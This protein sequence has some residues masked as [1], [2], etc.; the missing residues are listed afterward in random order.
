MMTRSTYDS[1]SLRCSFALGFITI[2]GLVLVAA[3]AQGQTRLQPAASAQTTATPPSLST[4]QQSFEVASIR[5]CAKDN[6]DPFSQNPFPSNRLALHNVS[7]QWA[8]AMAYKFDSRHISGPSW[9][10][11]LRY[12]IDAKV[13]GDKLL[14]G[15]EMAPLF[16]DLL[17]ERF[18]LVVRNETMILSGYALLT[19]A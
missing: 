16:Q 18:H 13:E 2:L 5:E 9:L 7:L 14:S 17:Q 11:D 6:H 4:L 3:F 8:I 1:T 19:T 12:S 10:N 15:E